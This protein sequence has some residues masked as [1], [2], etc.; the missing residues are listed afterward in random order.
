MYNSLWG[1]ESYVNNKLLL[2]L[3]IINK[4]SVCILKKIDSMLI[5]LPVLNIS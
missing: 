3:Y 5:T 4:Y 1:K 2:L